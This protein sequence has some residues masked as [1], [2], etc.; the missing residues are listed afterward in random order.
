[1][2]ANN[3]YWQVRYEKAA[4][5]RRV[6]VGLRP[7]RRPGAEDGPCSGSWPAAVRVHA[8]RDPAPG[9]RPEL[10]PGDYTVQS[11]R[12][13]RPVA[14][15]DRLTAGDVVPGVVSVESD[16]IPG[17]Q[18]AA[19]S[20][21]HPLTSSSTA[22]GA[23]TRTATPTR[24]ATP[25]RPARALR[26]RLA[27]VELG[28]RRLP[29][30]RRGGQ[31]VPADTRIQKF[32]ANAIDD[33]TRPAPPAAVSA[34]VRRFGV[35]LAARLLPRPPRHR[36][37]LPACGPAARLPARAQPAAAT[38]H[39]ATGHT[40]TR[41]SRPTRGARPIRRPRRRSSCPTTRR[42]SACAARGSSA[43]AAR[44]GSLPRVRPRPRRRGR[45]HR[46]LARERPAGRDR[47]AGGEALL[48]RARGA[49]R[50]SVSADDGHGGG[51]GRAGGS[52]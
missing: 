25:T 16:T 17:S 51:P 52:G 46:P 24:S 1:M 20:C 29:G 11:A 19:S 38:I 33:L 47:D 22:S 36:R 50:I 45:R 48:R 40:R 21:T 12:A 35:V 7:D 3:A 42:S 37:P 43:P 44:R 14:G 23:G 10:A 34:S 32:M 8:D 6:Q 2:G 4:D 26:E 15:R 18:S 5:D 31:G 28:A 13:G 9:R 30:Q 39:P 49:S 27:P 41:Q